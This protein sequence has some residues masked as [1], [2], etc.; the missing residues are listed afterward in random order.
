MWP[1]I[2]QNI[3]V[4]SFKLSEICRFLIVTRILTLNSPEAIGS[5]V[6]LTHLQGT[7]SQFRSKKSTGASRLKLTAQAGWLGQRLDPNFQR[8]RSSLEPARRTLVLVYS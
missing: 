6:L 1:I 2:V 7:V 5:F 4:P 3:E 8:D